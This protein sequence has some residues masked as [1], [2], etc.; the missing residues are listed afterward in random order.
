MAGMYSPMNQILNARLKISPNSVIRLVKYKGVHTLGTE[1]GDERNRY[2]V[3]VAVC[4][5][6]FVM[7]LPRKTTPKGTLKKKT[8]SK[9]TVKAVKKTAKKAARRGGRD[10]K[11]KH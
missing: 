3:H 11:S 9:G 5:S 4:T 7:P 6:L 10:A 2:P 8:V 1:K